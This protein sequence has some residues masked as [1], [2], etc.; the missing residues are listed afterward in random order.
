MNLL[1]VDIGTTNVKAVL[2]SDQGEMLAEGSASYPLVFLAGGGVE[3]NPEDWWQAC[4]AILQRFWTDGADPSAVGCVAVSGHGASLVM[5]DSNGRILRP[6]ISSLDTRCR[7]QTQRIRETSGN[8]ILE[9]N[10]NGVGAFNFEPKLK[11]I[12]ETDPMTY[13]A[14]PCFLSAT[15]YINYRLTGERIMNV[16]DAGIGMAFDR[17]GGSAGW[18]SA[19]I[20]SMG[21]DPEKFPPVVPC[22]QPIGIVHA[23]AARATGLRTGTPVIAGG[24]D[25]SSAALAMGIIQ[26]GDAYISLGTQG[27]VGVCTDR[28]AARPEIL[29][30]P[31]V[32]P[33]LQL[34]S[35]SM[36][37]F[38]ASM[39]WFIREWCG[40]LSRAYGKA[41][42]YAKITE[43][44]RH[45]EPGSK[46]LLFLPYL[47]GELHPLLDENA[48]GVF[49]GLTLEHTR[50][51]M[52]RSIM[53]GTAHAVLHNLGYAEQVSG[54]IGRLRATGGPTRNPLWCQVIADIT[55]R[56]VIVEC[57]DTIGGAP[58]GNVLLA[59]HAMN[60]PGIDGLLHRIR[61][62][63]KV[64][65]PTESN[66]ELYIHQ[67]R[68]YTELYPRLKD[69]FPLLKRSIHSSIERG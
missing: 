56:Q 11:W 43:A 3:Q 60:L 61:A 68:I 46:G 18:S 53:E 40:D 6:A 30:F 66:R 57:S 54:T 19:V 5:T 16:S 38:G 2:M 8:L 26:P 13:S 34:L 64:Y 1:G 52:A 63:E 10:G 39:E 9:V 20:E 42:V 50:E 35:G 67:H 48:A 12:K 58:V 23:G 69:I 17:R 33:G 59:M 49:I 32:L 4:C 41:E 55:G 14:M 27:T 31:H 24:E 62:N 44:C 28:F 22:V 29:G 37:S 65:E 45:T 21:L 7:L 25:T 15:S 36:S 47:S 51:D